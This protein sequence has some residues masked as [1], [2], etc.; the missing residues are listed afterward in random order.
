MCSSAPLAFDITKQGATASDLLEAGEFHLEGHRPSQV[1]RIL[2]GATNPI[3]LLTPLPI[4]HFLQSLP[5]E[6]SVD[7]VVFIKSR[8]F[9]IS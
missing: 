8:D 7:F 1:D 4:G 5:N 9:R 3:V 6:S 2:G